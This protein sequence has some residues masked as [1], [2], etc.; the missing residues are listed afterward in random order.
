VKK[1]IITGD[2]HA[3]YLDKNVFK[4]MLNYTKTYK[5]DIFV[6]NGDLVDAF[7]IS[8]FEKNPKRKTTLYQE[9]LIVINILKK[10]RETVGK[11]CNIYWTKGNHLDRLT[12][13][14]NTHIE[15]L[16][17]PFFDI[18]TLFKLKEFNVKFVDASSNYDKNKKGLGHLILGDMIIMHGDAK[19]N[20]AK[21]SGL[22]AKS[23]LSTA[24][25]FMS[26]VA[27]NH[28]HRLGMAYYTTPY[29]TIMGIE[30]GCMCKVNGGAS[31]N[32]GFVTFE[33]KGNKSCNHRIVS[34]KDI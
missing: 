20:G 10:I 7:S 24:M 26:N 9:A 5:P 28:T 31:W 27:M 30:C 13:Y 25:K 34:I 29:K 12:K 6:I 17:F 15:L 23:G 3:Q 8:S 33:V 2:Y 19:L 21:Y 11:K 1:V 4:K 16:D 14:L 32:Q 22:S 18:E